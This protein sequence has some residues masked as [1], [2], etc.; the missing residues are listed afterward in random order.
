MGTR[1]YNYSQLRGA[2]IK[3]PCLVTTTEDIALAGIQTIDGIS[4]A[5]GNRILVKEQITA[6]ENGIYDVGATGWNRSID[7]STNDD[8]FNG[9][10]VLVTSGT[11]NAGKLFNLSTANPIILDTTNLTF[12]E[13]TGIREIIEISAAYTVTEN[14]FTI[15]CI[16]N[17]F[18]V[19]LRSAVGIKGKIF[20]IK[21]SGPGIIT[22]DTT[23]TETIDFE[24]TQT[25]K[26][27]NAMT[28]QSTGS[29]YI[30]I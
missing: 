20:V 4:G 13:I 3:I 14:D 1:L 29:R 24:L 19:T 8:V 21:N 9:I 11:S 2:S 26:S 17:T 10:I 18:A 16:E 7:L 6:S 12:E 25:L 5:T 22:V 15:D 23:G 27:P 30:I 28:V